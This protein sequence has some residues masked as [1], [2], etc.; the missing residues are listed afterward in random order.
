MENLKYKKITVLFGNNLS[1]S[2]TDR[3]RIFVA[4]STPI[5][6]IMNMIFDSRI[7]PEQDGSGLSRNSKEPGVKPILPHPVSDPDTL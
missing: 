6:Y 5:P 2:G 4:G 1:I 3:F 7:G